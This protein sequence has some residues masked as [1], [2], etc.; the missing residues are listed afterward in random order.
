MPVCR[1]C[2]L[3]L[4]MS[5]PAVAGELPSAV[6]PA[7]VGVNIHFTRGH[8]RDLDLIAA[9]GFK[10][11]RMDF[12]WGAIE[13]THKGVYN[14]SA[15]D[16]LTADLEKRGLRAIYILDYSNPLYEKPARRTPSPQ[17]PASVAAFARF[18][19]MAARRYHGRHI[20]WEIWNEPNISF[21]KPKPNVQQYTTL[22]L[23]TCRAVRVAEPKATLIAPA[24]SGVPLGYL[25]KFFASGVLAYLDAVSLHPYRAY[26][27]P[28]E[29][30]AHDYKNVRRLIRR[31]APADKKNLPIISSEWGYSS[32]TRGVSPD[33]QAAYLVRMQLANLLD[34][35]RLSIWYDWKDDGTNRAETEQNFGTVHH[36]LRP[37]PAYE[38]VRTMTHELKG[39]HVICRL[40]VGSKEDYVLFL[41][42]TTGRF[43]LAAWTL[44][45][46]HDIKVGEVPMAGK[47]T[48][49]N[50][51][52]KPFSP[53]RAGDKLVLKVTALPRYVTL[54]IEPRPSLSEPRP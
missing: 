18:A 16:A 3:S 21:W 37:K 28:P 45:K 24:T 49:V 25:E 11:V 35:V 4:L 29:A 10:F 48:G 43:K 39:Y 31:Y 15:Y 23:A 36:N 46:P 5:A 38:A 53:A 12:E 51:S 52:G 14:W 22:A 1:V 30:A 34:G 54:P 26:R 13:V 8:G 9:A 27:Q 20:I 47:V 44:S 17:H 7:G 19:A 32:H 2:F 33:T 6:L 50:G 41:E 42:D 40:N